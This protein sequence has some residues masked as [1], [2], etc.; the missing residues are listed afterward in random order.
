MKISHIPKVLQATLRTTVT[1]IT[2]FWEEYVN[3]ESC[4][5]S[6]GTVQIGKVYCSGHQTVGKIRD[7]MAGMCFWGKVGLFVISF[8]NSLI[9]FYH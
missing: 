8:K 2:N 3:E 9:N 5:V 7:R 6:E 1:V 4:L